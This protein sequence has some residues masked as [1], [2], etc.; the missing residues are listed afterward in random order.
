MPPTNLDDDSLAETNPISSPPPRRSTRVRVAPAKYKDFVCTAQGMTSLPSQTQ[1]KGP[2]QLTPSKH[3]EKA[4]RLHDEI[5]IRFWGD[6][7][8]VV[9]HIINLLPSSVLHWKIFAELLLKKTVSYDH[10]K[11]EH[12]NLGDVLLWD[13]L[14]DRK[15]YDLDA[16]YFFTCRGI[17]F[18]DGCLPFNLNNTLLTTSSAPKEIPSMPLVNPGHDVHESH[19]SLEY[20][21][22]IDYEAN[23]TN[24][25]PSSSPRPVLVVPLTNLDDDSLA[26]IY[27]ISSPPPR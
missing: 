9:V 7:V 22:N 1:R 24:I 11:V 10:L 18:Q 25:I 27:P 2:I 23:S 26:E 20:E 12:H 6:C 4:M 19:D 17:I 16:K 5:P 21:S 15:V 14:W 3:K 8:L 13:T